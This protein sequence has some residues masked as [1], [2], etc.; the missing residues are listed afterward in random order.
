MAAAQVHS[1]SWARW[2]NRVAQQ[3]SAGL[4]FFLLA[5]YTLSTLDGEAFAPGIVSAALLLFAALYLAFA[6]SAH[7]AVNVPS[8]CL[9]LM[10]VYAVV[11]TLWFPHKIVY[12]GWAGALFWLS[13]AIIVLIAANL[14]RDPALA[15]R[16]RFGFVLFATAVCLLDLLEQASHTNKYFW[17]I[18]SRHPT[19]SGPFAYWNNFAEFEELALPITLWMGVS[20]WKPAIGYLVLAG[21]QMGAVIASGSRAGSAL[22]VIEFVA[23]MIIAYKRNRNKAF[24]GAAGAAIL[25]ALLFAY[26]AGFE[27]LTQ[28][29]EQR[30]QLRS[31]GRSTHPHWP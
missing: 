22:A 30:D 4:L 10:A 6:K 12:D 15:A 16:F 28:K 5:S 11:Q 18:E 1:A 31:G 25:A 9:L 21:L 20:G 8:V 19:V 17:I 24:L 7:F 23:L 26:A 27:A 2:N 3:V 13:A 14:F 29:I